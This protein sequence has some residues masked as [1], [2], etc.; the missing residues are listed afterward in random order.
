[1][2]NL[3]I[4][5][6]PELANHCLFNGCRLLMCVSILFTQLYYFMAKHINY[7]FTFAYY[8][9]CICLYYYVFCICLCKVYVWYAHE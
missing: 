5:Y 3:I 8:V 1:M 4:I 6:Q 9:F 7:K 2:L